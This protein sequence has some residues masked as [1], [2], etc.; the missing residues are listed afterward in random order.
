MS[1]RFTERDLERWVERGLLSPEQREA[2]LHDLSTSPSRSGLDLTALLYYGGGVLV[3]LAYSLFL[4]FQWQDV[5]TGGRI[6]ISGLS[7][8]FFAGVSQALIATVRYRLPGELLQMVAVV[9]VPL[10]AFAILDALGLWPE[11]TGFRAAHEEREAYQRDLTWARMAVA[12]SAFVAAAVAFGLSR[13]PFVLAA[14]IIALTVLFVD[15]SIQVEADRL[16]FALET[17]QLMVIAFMGLAT[18]V[19]GVVAI[20]ARERNYSLWLYALALAGL[21]VGLGVEVFPSDSVGWAVVWMSTAL[22]VL[23]LSLLLQ[24][25]LL[26][27]AGVAGIYAYFGKLVFDVFESA[28]AA[29][30]LVVLG[31]LILGAGILYQRFGEQ[32]YERGG[33]T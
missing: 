7:V 8:V 23:A 18:L 33:E 20:R 10:L 24:E 11:G 29:F 32:L 5:D 22:I 2:I 9:V 30:A 6:A 31:L 15:V 25:R 4:G 1:A 17:P 21:A 19:G 16:G 13:S 14:A 28:N 27:V 26:A 12:G 3:L